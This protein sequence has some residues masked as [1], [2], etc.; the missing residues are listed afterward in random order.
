MGLRYKMYKTTHGCLQIWMEFS[1]R[2]IELKTRNEIS[3]L[4]ASIYHDYS[5][6]KRLLLVGLSCRG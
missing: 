5:L 4:R 3:D 2:D 6:S 1:S